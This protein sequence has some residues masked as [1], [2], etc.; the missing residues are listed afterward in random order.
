MN[1]HHR[2]KQGQQVIP[3][4]GTTKHLKQDRRDLCWTERQCGGLGVRSRTGTERMVFTCSVGQ[5]ID[6]VRF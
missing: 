6:E 5:E 3:A 4:A 2:N 1:R